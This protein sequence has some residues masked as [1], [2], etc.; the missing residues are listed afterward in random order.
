MVFHFQCWNHFKRQWLYGSLDEVV[1]QMNA[2]AGRPDS[3]PPS[4]T[5]RSSSDYIV[6]LEMVQLDAFDNRNKGL[7]DTAARSL[8]SEAFIQPD[9]RKLPLPADMVDMGHV[10]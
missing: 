7:A 2:A 1:A 5:S 4:I 9:R 8:P 6:D 10:E 3:A